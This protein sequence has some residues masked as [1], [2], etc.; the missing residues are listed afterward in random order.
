MSHNVLLISAVQQSEPVI[1]IYAFFFSYSIMLHWKWLDTVPWAVQ[2]DLNSINLCSPIVVGAERHHPELPLGIADLLF[3]LPLADSFRC[4][5]P[6]GLSM[7]E[8]QLAQVYT[9]SWWPIWWLSGVGARQPR[10]SPNSG[11]LWKV[12]PVFWTLHRVGCEIASQLSF[13]LGPI[14]ESSFLWSQEHFAITRPHI[15]LHPGVD[16]PVDPISDNFR[17]NELK[18]LKVVRLNLFNRTYL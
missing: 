10:P 7:E 15:N 8:S 5:F 2:Q 1:H 13:S 4:Q 6:G 18:I 16:F 17:Q 11:Q 9:P 12:I 3:Q 14:L